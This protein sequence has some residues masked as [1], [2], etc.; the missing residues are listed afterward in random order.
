[1]AS[2]RSAVTTRRAPVEEVKIAFDFT[3]PLADPEG[4]SIE[5]VEPVSSPLPWDLCA[6][7]SRAREYSIVFVHGVGGDPRSSW[8]SRGSNF[9]PQTLL[10]TAIPEARIFSWGYKAS[11]SDFWNAEHSTR[12]L[13]DY[14]CKLLQDLDGVREDEVFPLFTAANAGRLLTALGAA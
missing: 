13:A 10:P 3:Q 1:M 4:A 14:G 2:K 6:N 12:K 11:L 8:T 5:Q 9:W 7:L